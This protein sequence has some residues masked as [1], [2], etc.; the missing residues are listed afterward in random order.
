M[1]VWS[2]WWDAACSRWEFEAACCF[3]C[4]FRAR[5]ACWWVIWVR[6]F[7]EFGFV[8]FI[9]AVYY[10]GICL[11]LGLFSRSKLVFY[12]G[13]LLEL[14]FLLS[15]YY[16][17]W[18]SLRIFTWPLILFWFLCF[19]LFPLLRIISS[20]G[21]LPTR[22]ESGPWRAWGPFYGP[23]TCSFSIFYWHII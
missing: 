2:I 18:E 7:T 11:L 23:F 3:L 5:R 8:V 6:F 21:T 12:I 17:G 9:V 20:E 14:S 1:S 15:S 22:A 10:Y 13:F 16:T 4:L 19:S